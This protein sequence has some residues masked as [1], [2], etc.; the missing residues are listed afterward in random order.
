MQLYVT[1]IQRRYEKEGIR[2]FDNQQSLTTKE[3]AELKNISTDQAE[4]ILTSYEKN[5]K[6]KS[7]KTKNGII[8]TKNKITIIGGGI[9]G[10]TL[11][12][13]LEKKKIE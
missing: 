1:S 13:L 7:H 11:G 12:N 9:S 5:K 8:W 2:L 4:K 3:Y 10:L 6:L